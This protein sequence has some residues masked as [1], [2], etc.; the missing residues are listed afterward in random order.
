M[1]VISI[2]LRR[3]RIPNLISAAAMEGREHPAAKT[4]SKPSTTIF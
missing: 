2:V 1:L 3:G 4:A